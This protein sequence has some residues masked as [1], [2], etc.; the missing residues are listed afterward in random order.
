MVDAKFF[1]FAIA[2]ES[3]VLLI[4]ADVELT[5]IETHDIISNGVAARRERAQFHPVL[6]L[7]FPFGIWTQ[8][9]KAVFVQRW[10]LHFPSA[11]RGE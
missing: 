7:T 5:T 4:K 1:Q 2:Y 9:R 11:G 6:S 3:D 8:K 10:F